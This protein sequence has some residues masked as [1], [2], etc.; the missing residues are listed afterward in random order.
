ME[1][2]NCEF[3]RWITCIFLHF[4][5]VHIFFNSILSIKNCV[6][7]SGGQSEAFQCIIDFL[8]DKVGMERIEYKRYAFLRKYTDLYNMTR[9][10]HIKKII[11]V[12]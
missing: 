3:Y 12:W 9:C 6:G 10:C 8:F 7:K 4:N 5:F 11:M 1:Y 2:L